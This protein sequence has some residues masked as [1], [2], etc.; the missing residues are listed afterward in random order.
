[1][2]K[3]HGGHAPP[4]SLPNEAHIAILAAFPALVQGLACMGMARK[5]ALQG[6]YLRHNEHPPVILQSRPA[7]IGSSIREM[8]ATKLLVLFFLDMIIGQLVS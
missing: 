8:P 1:M 2:R 5:I 3:H 6:H 7:Y 4:L